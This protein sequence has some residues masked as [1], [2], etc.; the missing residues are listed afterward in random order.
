MNFTE[1]EIAI[2][3][4][5]LKDARML[6]LE[7]DD[8]YYNFTGRAFIDTPYAEIYY[9]YEDFVAEMLMKALNLE[10]FAHEDEWWEYFSDCISENV[11]TQE[12]IDDFKKLKFLNGIIKEAM[13]D[14]DNI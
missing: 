3:I 12:I 7:Y 10:H 11:D 9:Y 14:I 2:A 6:F 13:E 8:I 5:E 4:N 1:E